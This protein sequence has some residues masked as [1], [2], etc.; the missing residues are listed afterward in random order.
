MRKRSY[1]VSKVGKKS[2]VESS[3]RESEQRRGLECYNGRYPASQ[4]DALLSELLGK[5]SN[6]KGRKM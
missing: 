1:C 6:G 4:A 5:P 3:I 2:I